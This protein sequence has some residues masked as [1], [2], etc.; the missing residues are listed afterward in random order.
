MIVEIPTIT[1]EQGKEV[2]FILQSCIEALREEYKDKIK[3]SFTREDYDYHGEC[4]GSLTACK[5]IAT[6]LERKQTH[7]LR[8]VNEL[9]YELVTIH[10]SLCI[11]QKNMNVGTK[12]SFFRQGQIYVYSQCIEELEEEL[13]YEFPF[14][15]KF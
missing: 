7:S 15:I 9:V 6:L 13:G 4:T 11:L 14:E 1:K 8:Q 12:D 3:R 5:Q 2:F 10:L